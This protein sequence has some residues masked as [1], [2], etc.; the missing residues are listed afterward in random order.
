MPRTKRFSQSSADAGVDIE[1]LGTAFAAYR[2]PMLC[3]PRI[4]AGTDIGSLRAPRS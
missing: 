3:N 4:G 1:R 2:Q